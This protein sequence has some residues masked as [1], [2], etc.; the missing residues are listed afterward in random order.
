MGS[1]KSIIENSLNYDL[2]AED[3]ELLE[4][5][6]HT[7]KQIDIASVSD[8]IS[9]EFYRPGYEKFMADKK[10]EIRSWVAAD[11]LID[12]NNTETPENSISHKNLILTLIGVAI[13]AIG[14][15]V[16]LM[17]KPDQEITKE[18]VRQY[19]LLSYESTGAI[20]ANRGESKQH[21]QLSINHSLL[22]NGKC[23][24][25]T[26]NGKYPEQEMWSQLYCAF[27][28]ND[29]EKID[30]YKSKIIENKYFNYLKL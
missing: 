23:A 5:D 3:I 7:L 20:D 26:I 2:S 11:A 19:A 30:L 1:K 13:I 8:K 15:Y 17:K 4:V 16:M 24:E 21:N 22:L 6:D 10:E 27:L 12:N 25:L 14:A 29:A 28:A 9:K 18:E